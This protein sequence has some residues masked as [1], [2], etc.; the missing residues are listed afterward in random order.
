MAL[1][2]VLATRQAAHEPVPEDILT[3]PFDSLLEQRIYNRIVDRGFTVVPQFSANGYNLDLVVVGAKGRLAI[4][5]DGDAWHGPDA[6]E[7]DLGRQRDLERCG[8]QFFRIRESA[9]YVDQHSVLAK[10][11]ETLDSLD[12][13]PS[14]WLDDL[15][16][17]DDQSA[18]DEVSWRDAFIDDVEETSDDP[19]L[20]IYASDALTSSNGSSGV[21]LVEGSLSPD[22]DVVLQE[23]QHTVLPSIAELLQLD[24]TPTIEAADES[25]PELEETHAPAVLIRETDDPSDPSELAPY[26]RYRGMAPNPL[27]LLVGR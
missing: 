8:W 9:W 17:V 15:A 27:P 14:D 19:V 11:W 5:C 22:A 21:H 2:V 16:D 7:A 25:M 3:E 12:I 18:D 23:P 10:L 20:G 13:R 6:Y 24:A 26:A 4:E 1:L